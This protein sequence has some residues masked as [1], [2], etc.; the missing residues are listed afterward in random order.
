MH[1]ALPRPRATRSRRWMPRRWR[2]PRATPSCGRP[3]P[4]GGRDARHRSLDDLARHLGAYLE[5]V[6]ERPPPIEAAM[7]ASGSRAGR[8]ALGVAAA[9]GVR[10]MAH[11]FIVGESPR[12]ALKM[13]RDLW[14]DGAATSVDLLGEAT[15]T[16][17]EADRYAARCLEALDVAGRR[18]AE[19]ARPAGAGGGLARPAAAREPVGEGVGAH[20]ADAPRGAR[21]GPRRR[22]GAHAPA[23]A[24]G[25][26]AGRPPAHRHGVAGRVRDHDGAGPRAAGRARVP[27][28]AVVGAWC[29]RPTCASRPS[30]STACSS[31]RARARASRRSPCGW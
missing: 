22:R 25:Q 20:A 3:V 19:V 1:A 8:Q 27:R 9:G 17:E 21:E 10:H 31:G 26:G 23:A 11:R 4:P 24:P 16:R 2:W 6:G 5:E 15:V 13:L 12:A 30:S 28:R 29:S 7:K 18:R 14:E